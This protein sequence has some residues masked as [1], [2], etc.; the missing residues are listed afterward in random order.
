MPR[1]QANRDAIDDRFSVLGFTVRSESPLFEIGVAT[2]PALFR[3]DQRVARTRRN[4]FSS[5]GAGV[6]RA[7][8]GEAVYLLPPDVLSNFVGQQKLYFGLAT[9]PENS[10]GAPNYVQSPTAGNMYVNLAGLTERGLRRLVTSAR[11]SSYG[12]VNGRDPSLEWGGD[13]WPQATTTPAANGKTNGKGAASATTPSATPAPYDDGFGHFPD[14]T[15]PAATSPTATASPATPGTPAPDGTTSI[16][17]VTAQALRYGARAPQRGVAYGLA[18]ETDDSDAHG[19]EGPIPDTTDETRAAA[20]AL[21]APAPEYPQASRFEPAASGNYT[22]MSSPRTIERVVIHITDGGANVNGTIA[23]FKN[24]AAKVSAHYVIGQDGEVVQMVRHNDKAWHASSANGNSIGIEHVANTRGLKPTGAQLCASAALVTWLCDQCGITPDRAHIQGHSEADPKTTHS[25]C[26]NAVWDWTQYMQMIDT[27]SCLAPAAAIAQS[28]GRRDAY[29]PYAIAQE[30]ITPFYDPKNPMSALTCQNDAFS[31]ARE[32]WFVGVGN[33]RLFPHSAICKL[34]MT[35]ADGSLYGGTGFYIGPKRILTCAHNLYG[36]SKVVVMPG[37][38][39]AGDTPYGS[40]TIQSSGWRVAPAY[41]GSSDW[42]HD[43]AVIDNVPIAAPNGKYFGFLNATPSDRMPIVVCGYSA[44]SDRDPRAD[45]GHRR[46]EAAPA[47]RLRGRAERPRGHRIPDPHAARRERL[48]GVPPERQQRALRRWSPP[49]TYRRA[50]R[51]WPN[52]GCFITPDKIDWIEGRAKSFSLGMVAHSLGAISIHWDDVPYL[53]QSSNNS[54]WAA[55]AAMVVGWR[56][57]VSI[58]DSS[59]A[60]M[61]PI[62]DAYRTGLWPKD[63][64]KLV[65]AWNLVAEPPACYTLEAWAQMLESY[66]PLYID[67][68]WSGSSGGHVRVLVGMESDGVADGSGTTMFMHDP[69]PDTPGRIKL[70]FA[71]FLELYENRTG[72]EGGELMYQILHADRI[73]SGVQPV[74]A[75]PFALT[76][77]SEAE[78]TPPDDTPHLMLRDGSGYAGRDFAGR[79]VAPGPRSNGRAGLPTPPAPIV[80]QQ[81]LRAT[82]LGHATT[83]LPSPIPGTTLRRVSDAEGDVIF[84][85]LDQLEGL[86]RPDGATPAVASA[87]VDAETI[88][89]SGW[90]YVEGDDGAR[91]YMDVEVK[92]QCDGT[93]LGNIRMDLN[94]AASSLNGDKLYLTGRIADVAARFPS[95]NPTCAALDIN[96]EYRFV[97]RDGSAVVATNALRLFGNGKHN[98]TGR[99]ADNG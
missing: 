64:R 46:R 14:A 22:A 10:K 71:D 93:S 38:N 56:D 19:I 42:A 45:G 30:I 24:P 88:V 17:P 28:L 47:R 43:L 77:A 15:T 73:P 52:R 74:T 31:L 51:Q 98:L 79:D 59:I 7:R 92:W 21:G 86:K 68:T 27:R 32:E 9:Y 57:R 35:G 63:R 37:S 23:W 96:V 66:G 18:D 80:Q 13:A 65:D 2:D 29:A 49:S 6:L 90:P 48:A 87:L 20:Q 34:E 81:G 91:L 83:E 62:I 94:E 84:W 61:V 44:Q 82:S 53:P 67:M 50:G 76:L 36:M 12:Q 4:F 97:R 75:A 11:A 69:W 70:K 58:S 89:L 40:C 25:G 33:T 95:D 55:S 78:I 3:A 39:A 41:T 99:W 54:C 8:R 72:N 16:T 1:I 85:E 5:R 26:P 60:Q